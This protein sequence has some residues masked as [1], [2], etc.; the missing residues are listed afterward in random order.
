MFYGDVSLPVNWM[1]RIQIMCFWGYLGDYPNKIWPDKWYS[2]SIGSGPEVPTDS[3]CSSSDLPE[4]YFT[5]VIG[6]TYSNL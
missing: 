5:R 1:Y 3:N 4:L 6:T 2:S